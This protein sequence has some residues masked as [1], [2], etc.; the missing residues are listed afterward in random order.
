MN[1]ETIRIIFAKVDYQALIPEGADVSKAHL[2]GEIDKSIIMG[3]QTNSPVMEIRPEYV[4]QIQQS[5]YGARQ[6]V[7][8]WGQLSFTEK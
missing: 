2:Y 7:K 1:D 8:I 4:F 5:I 3:K 6:A